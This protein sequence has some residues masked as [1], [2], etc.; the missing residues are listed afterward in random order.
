MGWRKRYEAL[1][2]AMKAHG[3]ESPYEKRLQEWKGN[4]ER[5]NRVTTQVNCGDYFEVR[6]RALLAHATQ[7]DPTGHWFAV[8]LFVQQEAWP[9]EDYE[10]A[11]SLVDSRIPEDDLFAGIPMRAAP[12]G[13]E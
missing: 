7:I 5:D 4:P 12:A 8:P 11:R 2:R 13:R 9:T 3:L 1:D 10:L 6:D